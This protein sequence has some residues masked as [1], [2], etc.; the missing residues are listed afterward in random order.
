MYK[1]VKKIAF[2]FIIGIVLFSSFL[3][4]YIYWVGSYKN[5]PAPDISESFGYNDKMNFSRNKKAEIICI[6]SSISLN[7]INSESVVEKFHTN[8]YLNLSSW[9]LNMIDVFK[10]LKTYSSIHKPAV[11]IISSNIVD[12]EASKSIKMDYDELKEFLQTPTSPLCLGKYYIKHFNLKITMDNIFHSKNLRSTNK[13]FNS[14]LYDAH[15]AVPFSNDGFEKNQKR[16]NNLNLGSPKIEQYQYLDSI[17]NY[18][19]QNKI[20][21]L[22]FQSPI[23]EG[24]YRNMNKDTIISHITMVGEILKKKNHIFVN[25]LNTTWSDKFFVDYDHLNSLGA[26]VY[27]DYCLETIE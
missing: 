20:R 18:C 12:F 16:W 24:V 14:I 27:T 22:F 13:V 15:G 4:I 26:K 25:S 11:C 1:L 5:L 3:S 10:L 6:G 7:N 17:S 8:S 23:R 19:H 2:F 21:L 9:G